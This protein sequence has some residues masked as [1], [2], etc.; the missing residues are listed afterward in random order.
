MYWTGLIFA[1]CLGVGVYFF[2]QKIKEIIANIRLGRSEN[3]FDQPQERWKTMLRVAFGQ[4]K[5]GQRPIPA[6]LHFLVYIGFVIINLE[7]LEICIDG[8]FGTHRIFSF[9]GSFYVFL[10]SS[11]E[12]LAVLV[13]V[14]CVLFLIRRYF[15]KIPRFHSQEL[16][17]KPRADARNILL[18]EIILMLGFLTMNSAE[19]VLSLRPDALVEYQKVNISAFFLTKN[20]NFFFDIFSTSTLISIERSAWWIHILG[21]LAF[22]NYLPYS[23]HFHII[24]A[25]PATYFSNLRKKGTFLPLPTITGEVQTMLDPNFVNHQP[26]PERFGAKDIDDLSWKNLLDAYSCTEC[27]RCTSV[28]PANTTGKLL[29]P[30]KILMDTRDRLEEIGAEKKQGKNF[31]ED[32]KTLLDTYISR[33]ELLACTTCNACTEACPINLDPLSII[34]QMRQYV[35]M[36]EGQSPQ[37]WQNM[38]NNVENLGSPWAFSSEN[39]LQWKE[40]I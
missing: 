39:R 35:L 14:S 17:E 15:L 26:V 6:L 24:L 37:A 12:I 10:I 3:R 28:C 29:S 4:S 27:G 34:L 8:L 21:I 2:I 16:T 36:D 31:K 13:I 22:L 30:R 19:A 20:F 32:G 1:L 7:V 9:L 38:L 40:E 33:E 23:K 5:M 25:F 18:I 11:F